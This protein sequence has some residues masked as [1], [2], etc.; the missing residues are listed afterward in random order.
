LAVL[1]LNLAIGAR[2]TVLA[3][4]LASTAVV[5]PILLLGHTIRAY[6]AAFDSR[7][8]V[9]ALGP[10]IIVVLIFEYVEF[11]KRLDYAHSLDL[12]PANLLMVSDVRWTRGGAASPGR[13]SGH[14]YN[15]SGRELVGLSLEAALYG[16]SEKLSSATADT[17]LDVGPGEHGSFTVATADFSAAVRDLPC[18]RMED[19]LAPV[20]NN[21]GRAL[22]CVYRITGTRGEDVDF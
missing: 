12:I 14:V 7:V 18:V 19:D 21:Q 15:R 1:S 6:R 9:P 13:L 20:V 10:I 4:A 2:S 17:D 22:E 11:S 5:I 16:G 8:L 3:S